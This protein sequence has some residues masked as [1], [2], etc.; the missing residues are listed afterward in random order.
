MTAPLVS[1]LGGL[2]ASL[3]RRVADSGWPAPEAAYAAHVFSS[4]P[5]VATERSNRLAGELTAAAVADVDEARWR[6]APVLAA[7]GY[8]LADAASSE[9]TARWVAGVERL[10]DRDPFPPDR[11]SFFYRPVE[12]LGLARGAIAAGPSGGLF[13]G[14]LAGVARDGERRVPEDVWHRGLAA[15]AADVLGTPWAPSL[16]ASEVAAASVEEIALL[17][18]LPTA[19]AAAGQRLLGSDERLQVHELERQLLTRAVF[20]PVG[21]ADAARAAVMA[22]ALRHAVEATLESAHGA[23]WQLDRGERDASEVVVNLCRR[24]PRYIL[25]LAAR[26]DGRAAIQITDEYDLQDNLHALLR[27]HFDDVRAEVWTPNYGGI[28]KRMD[29]LLKRG[30]RSL[31]RR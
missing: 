11:A 7:A 4:L 2:L 14:W 3:E 23:R 6:E 26:H 22:A 30:R 28:H 8:L 24:F 5:G 9:L 21:A 1:M 18:W 29:F 16:A 12:L 17:I 27:L 15:A 19:Y 25:Q 10:A 13:C 20:E 31:R